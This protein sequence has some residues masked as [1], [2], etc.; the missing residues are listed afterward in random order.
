MKPKQVLFKVWM[1]RNADDACK[2]ALDLWR[3]FAKREREREREESNSS[4]VISF[5]LPKRIGRFWRRCHTAPQTRTKKKT[6]AYGWK[7][8]RKWQ[9]PFVTFFSPSSTPLAFTGAKWRETYIFF[10]YIN[11]RWICNWSY[12]LVANFDTGMEPIAF[13][14]QSIYIHPLPLTR[15]AT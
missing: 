11:P 6:S 8:P 10:S 15:K 5:L 9:I 2:Q 4:R 7:W 12:F 14:A 13:S 3:P 1:I